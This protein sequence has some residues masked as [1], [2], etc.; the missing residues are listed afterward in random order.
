[1]SYPRIVRQDPRPAAQAVVAAPM[2][3]A[4][5]DAMGQVVNPDG[6]LL[7]GVGGMPVKVGYVPTIPSP[8]IAQQSI[9]DPAGW[10]AGALAGAFSLA[11]GLFVSELIVKYWGRGARRSFASSVSSRRST[12]RSSRRSAA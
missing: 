2:A 11:V 7:L 12:R 9:M 4:S 1:M 8:P 3:V 10:W 6:T 5:V